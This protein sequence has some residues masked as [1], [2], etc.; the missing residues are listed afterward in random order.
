MIVAMMNSRLTPANASSVSMATKIMKKATNFFKPVNSHQSH[1]HRKITVLQKH[2]LQNQTVVV[3]TIYVMKRKPPP[4]VLQ[5]PKKHLRRKKLDSRFV[6]VNA[7]LQ[8]RRTKSSQ[9]C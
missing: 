1:V 2:V 5:A 3:K 6:R 4:V 7:V 8:M 9:F